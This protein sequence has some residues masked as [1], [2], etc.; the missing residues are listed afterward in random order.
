MA[1]IQKYARSGQEGVKWGAIVGAV[2]GMGVASPLTTA[3]GTALGGLVGGIIVTEKLNKY[4]ILRR[5]IYPWAPNDTN[6]YYYRT[7]T[8]KNIIKGEYLGIKGTT[9]DFLGTFYNSTDVDVQLQ[10]LK[11]GQSYT[12]TLEKQSFNLLQSTPN[13]PTSIRP[14]S[15]EQ[16]AFTFTKDGTSIGYI[17]IAPLGIGNVIYNEQTKQFDPAGPMMYTYEVYKEQDGSLAVSLQGL[18]IGNFVQSTS[19]RIRDINPLACHVWI[20]SAAQAQ[21]AAQTQQGKQQDT[22]SIPFDIPEIVWVAYK[23]KDYA[24]QQ[25]ISVGTVSDFMIMRPQLAEQ[26]A[27]LYCVSLP[28]TDETKAKKFLDRLTNGIIGQKAIYTEIT[29]VTNIDITKLQ[30][31]TNGIVDDSKGTGSSGLTGYILFADRFAPSGVGL[32]PFYYYVPAVQLRVDQLIANM[33]LDNSYYTT[34]ES[35]STIMKGEIQS[36]LTK[37]FV[38]WISQY[39]KDPKSVR[40]DVLKYLQQKG[41]KTLF[42]ES[43]SAQKSVNP[44]TGTEQKTLTAQ[45]NHLLDALLTGPIS[46]AHYPILRQAGTN[47]YVFALGEKPTFWPS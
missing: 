17:P 6:V 15:N 33:L 8:D 29:D 2:A 18:S 27:W 41:N 46:I 26:E 36:E 20:Q 35:G 44:L 9:S 4:K 30:P 7:Y 28:M 45:G 25:K 43:S 1:A 16:R 13:N 24:L 19:T 14:A 3:L 12:I 31:N 47:Y 38:Q 23:T 40:A 10:F 5:D 21:A 37:K 11:D 34:D 39:P 22:G 42:T 32:G